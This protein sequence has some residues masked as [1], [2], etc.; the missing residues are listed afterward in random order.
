MECSEGHFTKDK[1]KDHEE[2]KKKAMVFFPPVLLLKFFC[3]D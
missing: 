2:Q 3:P 1:E